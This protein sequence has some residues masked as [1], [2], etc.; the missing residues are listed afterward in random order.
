MV[1]RPKVTPSKELLSSKR[2]LRGE[3]VNSDIG[4]V[5]VQPEIQK[6]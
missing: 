1:A 6:G 4:S 2:R 5:L 3:E